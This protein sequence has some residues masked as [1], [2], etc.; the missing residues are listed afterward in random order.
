MDIHS[1]Y[2][3]LDMAVYQAD[4]KIYTVIL[5]IYFGL[6]YL[7]QKKNNYLTDITAFFTMLNF[8][9]SPVNQQSQ[10]KTFV[11]KK[12]CCI[13]TVALYTNF[14]GHANENYMLIIQ[15]MCNIPSFD[16]K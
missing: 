14:R 8:K 6:L 11:F 16:V 13:W 5:F 2:I 3:I 9:L 4:F 12:F 1:K 15:L 10:L 7:A